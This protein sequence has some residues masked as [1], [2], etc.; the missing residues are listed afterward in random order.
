MKR[1]PE[2]EALMIKSAAIAE[3]ARLC[4]QAIAAVERRGGNPVQTARA[5]RYQLA[6][7]NRT[8]PRIERV[9]CDLIRPAPGEPAASSRDELLAAIELYCASGV[10]EIER[11][12]GA[13]VSPR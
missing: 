1:T 6:E 7:F 3:A 11:R 2:E 13:K 10:E 5:K 12:F 8:S 4:D 9:V